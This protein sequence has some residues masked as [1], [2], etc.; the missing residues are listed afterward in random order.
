MPAMN[1]TAANKPYTKALLALA[2]VLALLIGLWAARQLMHTPAALPTLTSGTALPAPRP[3]T[4]F[5]LTD[6]RGQ[7]FDLTRFRGAW[8]LLFFGY[9]HCPDICPTTLATLNSVAKKIADAGPQR[10]PVR[11]VFV[12]VDPQR[13]TVQRLAEYVP[14]F[15]KDFL[16]VTGT[17]AQL[18]A[19]TAQLNILHMR[20][21]ETAADG[22]YTVD[23]TASILLIDPE[24]RFSAIFSAPHVATTLAKDFL[25][26]RSYYEDLQ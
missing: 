16:G 17:P 25:S 8:T 5:T 6:H 18:D 21:S 26:L 10:V 22:G 7:P 20:G 13:D 14:Y 9:T 23:H 19:F 3:L 4:P 15:N 1:Q 11:V 24:A 12:S 2:S